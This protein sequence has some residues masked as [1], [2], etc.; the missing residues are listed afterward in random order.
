[1]LA[2]NQ[3]LLFLLNFLTI[4]KNTSL[5]KSFTIHTMAM[6]DLI[7]HT[8]DIAEYNYNYK[9]ITII[10]FCICLHLAKAWNFGLPR[11]L[12]SHFLQLLFVVHTLSV[13]YEKTI[14]KSVSLIAFKTETIIV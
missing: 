10:Y 3:C 7:L 13:E 5:S 9:T 8:Q 11:C 1:M 6:R 14:H 4:Y 12:T 2:C